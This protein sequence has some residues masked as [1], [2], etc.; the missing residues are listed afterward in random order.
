MGWYGRRKTR[1]RGI[2]SH[3]RRKGFMLVD[4]MWIPMTDAFNSFGY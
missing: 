4:L 2:G 3:V 1:A